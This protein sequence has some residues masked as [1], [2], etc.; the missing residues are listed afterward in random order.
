MENL[1]L[2]VSQFKIPIKTRNTVT[3]NEI[4]KKLP[5]SGPG[6]KWGK[7]YYFY[8][9]LDIKIEKKA[10]E[11]ITKGEIAYWPSGNA[12]AIGYGPT[13]ISIKNE[14][15]LADKCNIWADTNFDLEILENIK[16]NVTI[17]IDNIL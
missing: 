4:L 8:T 3:A 11:V 2:K 9:S 1:I 14:I 16:G 5:L 7:E 17:V 12:I 13:P 15:R 10:K 6:H